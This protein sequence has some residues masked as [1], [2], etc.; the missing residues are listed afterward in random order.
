[1]KKAV[2]DALRRSCFLAVTLSLITISNVFAQTPG[3]I[4]RPATNGGETI[5]D[6]NTDGYISTSSTGFPGSNDIGPSVSEIPYR[7][8]PMLGAEPIGDVNKGTEGGHTDFASPS[9]LQ[10]YY[11][12][13]NLMFRMRVGGTSSSQRGYSVLIDSDNTF[14][15]TGAN[16]GFE[17]EIVY[18]S[19][20][21]VKLIQHNGTTQQVLLAGTHRQFSQRAVAASTAGGDADYF[22]DFYV[23]VSIF[24]GGITVNTP[25]RM[26]G[27]TFNIGQSALSDLSQVGDVAGVDF[28]SYNQQ[29]LPAW[30]DI[31]ET[32]PPVT[33]NDLVTGEIDQ[34]RTFP[35]TISSPITAASTVISGTSREAAGTL[36]RV[37]RN[38]SVIGTT[39]VAAD[40]T[41][42][43]N[44]PANVTLAAGNSITSTATATGRPISVA[45]NTVI[46]I[47]ADCATPI[48][49][50]NFTNQRRG[51]SGTGALPN[52]LI[53]V[54][55]N[56]IQIG[57]TT[58][59]NGGNWTLAI[60]PQGNQ[61]TNDCI[62]SGVF[63]VTQQGAAG[64][65]SA[66]SLPRTN[67][68]T[69]GSPVPTIGPTPVCVST[70]TLSGTTAANAF[71]TLFLN[72]QPIYLIRT[73]TDA[74]TVQA[75][76]S[77]NWS[78]TANLGYEAD[79]RLYVRSRTATTYYGQSTTATVE[80]CETSPPVIT[81][82]YCGVTTEVF[83]TS[84]EPEGTTIQIYVAG[85]PV[86]EPGTV[87]ENG[88]WTVSEGL[89][90]PAG[91]AFTARAT[92][93]G[94][95]ESDDSAPVTATAQTTTEGLTV[96]GPLVEG[97]STITGTGI[98]GASLTLYIGGTPYT[99]IVI[100]PD[101]IWSLTGFAT[102][103]LFPGASISATQTVT[104]QCESEQIDPIFVECAE[105]TNTFSLTSDTAAVLCGGSG[106]VSITLGGSQMGVAYSIILPN[107]D[108]TGSSVMGTGDAITLT[109]APITN[110][111]T[112]DA[113]V[114][115]R[116]LA[117]RV[118]G[119]IGPDLPA[120]CETILLSTITRTILPQPATDYV[121]TPLSS[122]ICAGSS[123][124]IQ[125]STSAIG[126]TYQLINEV[127]QE[128]VGTAVEGE[129]GPIV[130]STGPITGN[131]SYGVVIAN[132]ANG[133]VYTDPSRYTTTIS[134]PSIDR[135]F[136]ALE[137]R[138]CIGGSTTLFI[139]TQAGY[140][141][142]VYLEGNA[143]PLNGTATPITGTVDGI[144]FPITTPSAAGT[145]TYYV[146]VQGGG[147]PTPV[148]F[149][150]TATIET[151]DTPATA[152][153]GDD[154]SVCG[155]QATLV[156]NQASP[157]TGLW[158]VESQPEGSPA[159]T[160]INAS[161][162][163]IT[164]TNLVPGEY[165]FRWTVTV[166]CGET[167]STEFDE[168]TL[169]VNCPSIYVI[170]PPKYR[171]EYVANEL[172]AYAIDPDG[173]IA[174]A[175]L[176]SGTIPVGMD[177]N[178]TNGDIFV[179]NPE[180]LQTGLYTFSV[181]LTDA[182]GFVTVRSVTIEILEDS[183]VIVPLPVELVYFTASVRNNQA[184]LEWLTASEL[185]NDRFEVER[186][187]DAR[188]FEKI[189]EVKG[190]GTTS[191]ESK[192]QFTDRTPVEGTVYY[193]LKQVDFDGQFAYSSV[194]AVTA[195]G[196]ARELTTQAYPNPF[197]DNV[198]VMLM[199]PQAQ[200]AAMTIYDINGRTVMTRDL[201]LDA[202]V[203][204]LELQLGELRSGMYILKIVSEGMESTTRIMKN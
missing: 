186:S 193:R 189:G 135:P 134:G 71:V 109:S 145:Y 73:A 79:D 113:E 138:V 26:V 129:N 78:L 188:R 41:W 18:T 184:H 39:T 199:A 35:P 168:L 60:C 43:F 11:D 25:L 137:E 153:V 114:E 201:N 65:E 92:A 12:G 54:Y 86:G 106:T 176:V 101:G 171:D 42:T 59:N 74:Y 17:Y 111:G 32:F 50:F 180:L 24:G 37:L 141:Y 23:P 75:N 198:K 125:L 6:P 147:C 9:P 10:A 110:T 167:T 196:L 152:N 51:F 89:E 131:H 14:A 154:R 62:G 179:T 157:G 33:L 178:T 156:A 95:A 170:L 76:A 34:I 107:G 192:Y 56:G 1:M 90:V 49:T 70:T 122:T 20:T 58:A 36:I 140:L 130:L 155:D 55:R 61:G 99:P 204:N 120:S 136:I 8:L 144:N 87:N 47:A 97:S 105:L 72:D 28:R 123:V 172:L 80:T 3:L 149:L 40:G 174:S 195:K 46:V 108:I 66:P 30:R 203:N 82:D 93:P 16:P 169:T 7:P 175:A 53:R 124:N 133:C 2:Q 103:E 57:T 96:N 183:P 118:T 63:T 119:T 148:R 5:L 98:G 126:Y 146:T 190:K 83:G 94:G 160:I 173:G 177:L 84:T 100:P 19:G 112:E 68:L 161:N 197:R 159:P 150:Q 158:T 142:N 143:V 202:G 163:I 85:E 31:I 48:P 127:T 164:V 91:T 45:S 200:P 151:T 64:C 166:T 13:T 44:V 162:P 132:L 67:L 104:G 15:G 116:V 88:F 187:G 27:S 115:L 21:D 194:I 121:L 4:I 102:T 185:D 128:L 52:A 191:L 181:Q 117:R 182:A 69:A 139:S 38:G 165:V 81:G 29:P 22:L 77:G